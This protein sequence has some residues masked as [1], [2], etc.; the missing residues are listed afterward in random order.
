[1]VLLLFAFNLGLYEE[2]LLRAE[3]L[4][5]IDANDPYLLEMIARVYEAQ[6]RHDE[7]VASAEKAVD[8]AKAEAEKADRNG[9]PEEP[10]ILKG[11]EDYL[12]QLMEE[13]HG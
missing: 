5:K 3:E 11:Y 10:S 8:S 6:G 1:M 12:A 13:A 4:K 7:A 9:K 2:A